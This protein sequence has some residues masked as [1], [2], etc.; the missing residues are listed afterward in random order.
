[1]KHTAHALLSRS[2]AP[3]LVLALAVPVT[4]CAFAVKHPAATAGIVA[5]SVALT[6]CE[7]ASE[8]HKNCFIAG[9]AVGLGLA[10]VAGAAIWLGS[11]DEPAPAASADPPAPV[12]WTRVPDTTPAAPTSAPPTPGTPA[13]PTPTPTTTPTAPMTQPTP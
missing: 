7:L 3:L 8:D 1:M 11:E 6:T 10:L 2:L 12:D 4:G 13:A 9:G 5:G